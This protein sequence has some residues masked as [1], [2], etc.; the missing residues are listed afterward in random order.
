M[1]RIS[2]STKALDLFG[3]G[4]HG[5]RDG[6]LGSGILPTDFNAAWCNDFQEEMM[7]IIEGA[8]L[9][10]TVGVRNQ[11]YQAIQLMIANATTDY[12]ASVR[13]TTTADINLTGLGTQAGGDWGAALTAGDRILVKN[14][15]T[16]SQNGLYVASAGAWSRAA[17]ADGAGEITA[18]LQVT[19]EEGVTLADST[20]VLATDNPISIGTTALTFNRAGA[21]GPGQLSGTAV[22][23][24]NAMTV[25]INPNVVDFRSPTLTSGATN[26]RTFNAVSMVIPQGALLGASAATA[27]RIF[28]M[29]IDATSLGG[30]VEVAVTPAA[31]A[32]GMDETGVVSTEAINTASAV[33]ASIASNGLMTVSAV[34]SGTI[35]RGMQLV[36][37]GVPDGT[38]I[39]SF[40]TGTG[41]TGTYNTN[42]A[43]TVASTTITGAAGFGVYSTTARANV[44]YKMA[45]FEDSTQASAGVYATQP[46]LVGPVTAG[47][48]ALFA[49]G[50]GRNWA[51]ASFAMSTNYFTKEKGVYVVLTCSNI[52]NGGSGPIT[53][54]ITPAGGT[55]V[56]LTLGLQQAP[57]GA[58]TGGQL[59]FI[60]ANSMWSWS[61][62]ASA[63]STFVC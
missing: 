30:G 56:S 62:P 13:F 40:G 58:Y 31:T 35:T 37:A 20:W 6:N 5:F 43:A 7:S 61:G 48:L 46:T 24:S 28:A 55:A 54:N 15:A 59:C 18:G 38:R 1:D 19:V 9:T 44:P 57:G 2:T 39:T 41:G 21:S 42:C 17:D 45:I 22:C 12:K 29:V 3:T 53:V 16:P 51:S 14:E 23:A 4:K 10:P 26:R 25:T 49:P 11:V 34:I 27:N 8:G 47:L 60:P 36:G 63:S 52:G 32:A 33:T 50:Y